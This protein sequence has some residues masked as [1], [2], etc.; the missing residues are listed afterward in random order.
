MKTITGTLIING[1]SPQAGLSVGDEII[2]TGE[3]GKL[4][5]TITSI[6][7]QTEFKDKPIVIGF[8]VKPGTTTY[9][10]NDHPITSISYNHYKN[11]VDVQVCAF[12]L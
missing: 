1:N 5:M 10:D 3:M 8:K 4:D 7:H 11:K 12:D 9:F 6:K 2:G